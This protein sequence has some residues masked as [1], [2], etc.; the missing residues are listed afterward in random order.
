MLGSAVFQLQYFRVGG[1]DRQRHLKLLFRLSDELFLFAVN[2]LHRL[3]QPRRDQQQEHEPQHQAGGAADQRYGE[4]AGERLKLF[5]LLQCHNIF[6]VCVFIFIYAVA[7]YGVDPAGFAVFFAPQFPGQRHGVIIGKI[8]LV[9]GVRQQ[10]FIFVK[11]DLKIACIGCRCAAVNELLRGPVRV[12]GR[13][14]KADDIDRRQ[15]YRHQRQR[16][17]K[18]VYYEFASESIHC[19]SPARSPSPAGTRCACSHPA[20][21][22]SC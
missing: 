13:C 17:Q 16:R 2:A 6:C 15:Q 12:A 3:Q 5:R 4:R 7:V 8:S 21:R 20:C 1:N 22:I 18:R 9:D 10:V 14:G 11:A 19:P